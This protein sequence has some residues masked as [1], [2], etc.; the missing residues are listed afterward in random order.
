VDD[1]GGASHCCTAWGL[2]PL[3]GIIVGWRTLVQEPLI[4]GIGGKAHYLGC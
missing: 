1:S 4:Y 2:D 3:L